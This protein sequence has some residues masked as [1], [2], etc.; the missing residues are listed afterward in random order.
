MWEMRNQVSN[1]WQSFAAHFTQQ[2][3]LVKAEVDGLRAELKAVKKT[4]RELKVSK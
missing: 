1:E 2:F 4:V 3:E